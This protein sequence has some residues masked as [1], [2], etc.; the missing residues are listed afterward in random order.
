MNLTIL[1][2]VT[3]RARILL[4]ALLAFATS[5]APTISAAGATA[6]GLLGLAQFSRD[7]GAYQPLKTRT[8]LKSGDVIQTATGSSLDLDL[9]L[10]TA[11]LRLLQSTTLALTLVTPTEIQLEL[12][13][14]E[15]VGNAGKLPPGAK[16]RIEVPSGIAGILEGDFRLNARAYL[17]VVGGKAVFVESSGEEPTVHT[18]TGSVY[19]SPAE[20]AV[21]PAPKELERDVRAQRKIRL[22]K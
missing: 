3:A 16:F 4:L 15:I 7:G 5:Y 20:H 17:V 21:K 12:K 14:G 10:G 8:I 9:G 13:G 6:T 22:P 18:L 2:P 19:F 1:P 11:K